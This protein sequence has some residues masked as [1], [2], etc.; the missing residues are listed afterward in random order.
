MYRPGGTLTELS[1][2][3]ELTAKSPRVKQGKYPRK[4]SYTNYIFSF[5]NYFL[6]KNLKTLPKL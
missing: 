1:P 4:N 3:P 6:L 2:P 5:P